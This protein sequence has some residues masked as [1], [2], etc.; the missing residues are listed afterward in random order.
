[1]AMSAEKMEQITKDLDVCLQQRLNIDMSEENGGGMGR[2]SA[3]RSCSSGRRCACARARRA[4]LAVVRRCGCS[5]REGARAHRRRLPR[6]CPQV[7]QYKTLFT[8]KERSAIGSKIWEL[9]VSD[10]SQR[11]VN[12]KED[13]VKKIE[14][15]MK[16]GKLEEDVFDEARRTPALCS[17]AAYGDLRGRYVCTS[18]CERDTSAG[19]PVWRAVAG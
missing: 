14:A 5:H 1:M 16:S 19:P 4:A 13:M 8:A 15:A 17:L 10:D 18:L 9:Y 2:R 12:L 3:W 7:E 11:K 6:N